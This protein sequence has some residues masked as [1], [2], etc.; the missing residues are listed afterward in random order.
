MASLR[1]MDR[2]YDFGVESGTA[3]L[4]VVEEPTVPPGATPTEPRTAVEC[5]Q[6]YPAPA[7]VEG[8]SDFAAYMQNEA[9]HERVKQAKDGRRWLMGV[10]VAF[11][12]G[13]IIGRKA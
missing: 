6:M 2:P 1:W 10:G 12:A 13:F 8:P 7:S 11:I 5:D 3:G 9:C 4:G